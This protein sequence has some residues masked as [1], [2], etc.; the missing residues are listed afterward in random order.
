MAKGVLS[1]HPP[2]CTFVFLSPSAHWRM[3]PGLGWE[4]VSFF[5]Q[6]PLPRLQPRH[7]AVGIQQL[8]VPPRGSQQL[9]WPKSQCLHHLRG[10]G[11]ECDAG[12]GWVLGSVL[13][14]LSS[15]RPLLSA[16]SSFKKQLD[17]Q[18]LLVC[19]L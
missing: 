6:F 9:L 19:L 16:P 17:T 5:L 12:A 18:S 1:L 3:G 15:T 8:L 10:S 4:G 13:I 2:E 7:R 11:G 14:E